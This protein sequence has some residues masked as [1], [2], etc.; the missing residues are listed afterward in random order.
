MKDT[1]EFLKNIHPDDDII[2]IFNNDGDGICSC[3]MLMKFLKMK[4]RPYI[5][6]QPMPMDKNLVNRVKTGFPKKIIFLD[7]NADQQH[8]IVKKLEGIC[9]I[10]IIDHHKPFRNLNSS[11]VVHHNPRFKDKEIYQ[12]TS[13]LVYKICSEIKDMSDHL[14]MA[15]VGI[16]SDYDTRFSTDVVDQVKEKYKIHEEK[17]YDTLFGR[18]S[19]M[20]SASNSTKSINCEYIVDQFFKANG[21]EEIM[22]NEKML[23]VYTDVENE[24]KRIMEDFDKTGEIIGNFIFYNLK[25][26]YNM[27]SPIST[28]I[29][30]KHI[31]KTV[32][33]YQ[34]IGTKVKLSMRNQGGK[35]DITKLLKKATLGLKASAGGHERAAGAIMNVTDWEKFKERLIEQ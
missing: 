16:V 25:S 10:L 3:S 4:K 7:L 32:I 14:W 15:A 18:I 33:V 2:I 23:K 8:N 30:D 34:K 27:R 28:K 29:S 9:N 35:V 17:L 24:I 19:D 12:S 20:I 22:N 26:S 21:P 6:S 11:R 31:G 1:I 13:Y 5:I